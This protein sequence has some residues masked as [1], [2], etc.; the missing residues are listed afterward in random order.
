MSRDITVMHG[1][2]LDKTITFKRDDKEMRVK[3][4]YDGK[5]LSLSADYYEDGRWT[6]GGQN[7]ETLRQEFIDLP[8]AERLRKIWERWHLND[9]RAGDEAQEDYLRKLKYHGWE[10]KSYGRACGVL[11]AAGLL[12]H[13]GYRYGTAWNFEP[14]PAHIIDELEDMK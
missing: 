6:A 1:G 8:N 4:K 2:T 14:V 13:N 12:T 9:M 7:S 5:R 11:D 3:V 10:Y